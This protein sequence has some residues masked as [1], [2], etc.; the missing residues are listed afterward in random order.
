LAAELPAAN[1]RKLALTTANK[2]FLTFAQFLALEENVCMSYFFL[3]FIDKLLY[4][5]LTA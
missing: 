1:N 5:E 2:N 3:F 4:P